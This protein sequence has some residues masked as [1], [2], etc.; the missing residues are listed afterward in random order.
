MHHAVIAAGEQ[1]EDKSE[2]SSVGEVPK[3]YKTI[4]TS[5]LLLTALCIFTLFNQNHVVV[6]FSIYSALIWILLAG[7]PKYLAPE[8]LQGSE[9]SIQSDL[10]SLGCL[11]YEMYTGH[12]PF[13]GDSFQ[14]LVDRILSQDL[15]PPKVK[16]LFNTECQNFFEYIL[17]YVLNYALDYLLNI[18]WMI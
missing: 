11:L 1:W 16:G 8:V 14:Q 6:C 18:I 4:G 12:P 3:K 13:N 5:V 15:P 10:W 2:R 9:H 17:D 7:N